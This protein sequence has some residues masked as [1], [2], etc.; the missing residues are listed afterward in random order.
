MRLH[1]LAG[2]SLIAIARRDDSVLFE[3]TSLR[4]KCISVSQED[5]Q[6]SRPGEIIFWLDN[7]QH[8]TSQVTGRSPL[9]FFKSS[10]WTSKASVEKI[11]NKKDFWK[12]F[13]KCG[14]IS[15]LFHYQNQM[16]RML[17]CSHWHSERG[18]LFINIGKHEHSGAHSLVSVWL[19]KQLLSKCRQAAVSNGKE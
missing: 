3:V 17:T 14:N 11:S 7:E 10:F 15:I 18:K 12:E 6:I 16:L 19:G 4:G 2:I 8:P 5:E 9:R 1:L 13:I